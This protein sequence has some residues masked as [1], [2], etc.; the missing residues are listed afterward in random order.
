[1]EEEAD[2]ETLLGTWKCV[3]PCHT[4]K[5]LGMMGLFHLDDGKGLDIGKGLESS[6]IY[7]GF[8]VEEYSYLWQVKFVLARRYIPEN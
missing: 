2:L 5:R 4:K 1:M 8:G 6:K 7:R 3:V